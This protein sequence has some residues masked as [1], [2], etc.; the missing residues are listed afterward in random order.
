MLYVV[1]TRKDNVVFYCSRVSR[2]SR[3]SL[4]CSR[5]RK[6]VCRI[7]SPDVWGS[8]TH[9]IECDSAIV[10]TLSDCLGVKN[11]TLYRGNHDLLN[12]GIQ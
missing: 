6:Q 7:N 10:D 1:S 11:Y 4:F 12:Q 8:Y 9:R 5:V 3:F 2:S